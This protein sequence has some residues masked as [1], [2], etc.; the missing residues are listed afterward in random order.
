MRTHLEYS[1]F[2]AYAEESNKSFYTEFGN[3]INIIF[4]K[5][6]SGK[7]T[8]IQAI[9]YTFGINDEKHKLNEILSENV[10]FRLDLKVKNSLLFN[11]SI[12]RDNDFIFIHRENYPVRKFSGINGNKSEEHIKLKS[13]LSELF[14]F[15]LFLE[16]KNDYKLGSIESMFL[17]YYV[18]QDYGWVLVLK[19]FRG[20]DYFRNFK[21]DYYDYYLGIQ[22][23][24][25]RE[26]KQQLEAQRQILENEIRFLSKT[27]AKNDKLQ[28]SKLK[29]ESFIYKSS[30][31]IEQYKLDKG[32]L[33]QKEKEYVVLS[34]K[35]KFLE[36][37]RKVLLA[38]NRNSDKQ[39]PFSGSC[40]TC[41]QTL[42]SSIDRVYE[43]YQDLNDTKKQLVS[44]KK[45]IAEK[46]GN[47]NSLKK[48][49]IEL[50]EVI[51]QKYSVLKDY[52]VD[53]LSVG[54]WLDNKA[55]VNLSNTILHQIGSLQIKLQDILDKLGKY[56]TD[57]EIAHERNIKESQ[58]FKRF[59]LYLK[60][61]KV[62][63]PKDDYRLY[64]NKLFPQQGVELLKTLLAYYFSFNKIIQDT[65]YVHRFPFVMDAIFKEDVDE[66]NRALI[67]DFIFKNRP[68]DTQLIFSIAESNANNKTA[69]HYNKEHLD[70]S[71]NLIEINTH[72]ERAFLSDLKSEL[73]D[74]K[75]ETLKLIE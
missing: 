51:T 55:N 32:K 59:N 24:F 61:L 38:I 58:F 7:S 30:E 9:N 71:A 31:Y 33:I 43:Y 17:P 23:E 54:S 4:G 11:V 8:L 53:D 56:K 27:E 36:E 47:L 16:G 75:Y 22:N 45:G 74:I 48:D 39:H 52:K 12:I 42:P 29:D 34:N 64:S 2:F 63:V 68:K 14:R 69:A 18:A 3:G 13:Y 5:N 49:I 40:P 72:M 15:N 57:E 28:L 26:D 10:I 73:E 35:I 46:T 50:R 25:D 44:N 21:F 6:T 41:N 70:S 65:S 66:S 62:K 20:L 67:L 37:H 19:S 1:R 60:E